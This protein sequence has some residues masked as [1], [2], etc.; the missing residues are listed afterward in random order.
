MTK[1]HV[2]D[3]IA[4]FS[5]LLHS[6]NQKSLFFFSKAY[7]CSMMSSSRPWSIHMTGILS[8][9][10][11]PVGHG[12]VRSASSC[13]RDSNPGPP[14]SQEDVLVSMCCLWL[15]HKYLPGEHHHELS[16]RMLSTWSWATAF[17]PQQS[18]AF[19][20]TQFNLRMKFRDTHKSWTVTSN[21]EKRNCFF[22]FPF[23]LTVVQKRPL[24]PWLW[25]LSSSRVSLFSAWD[26]YLLANLRNSGVW[27][28]G[29]I[30]ASEKPQD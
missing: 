18:T 13:P 21:R 17:L 15:E 3:A 27:K 5:L 29:E 19:S 14:S 7:S 28:F 24:L 4:P 9:L 22:Q 23:A 26:I 6:L 11:S 10:V 20:H 16:R 8:Q 30:T 2:F 1:K 25:I 12:W